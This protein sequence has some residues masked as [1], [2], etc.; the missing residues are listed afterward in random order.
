MLAILCILLWCC[1]RALGRLSGPSSPH[2]TPCGRWGARP[3]AVPQQCPQLGV[4]LLC[5]AV[6]GLASD[7]WLALDAA[8]NAC[9]SDRIPNAVSVGGRMVRRGGTI[10]RPSQAHACI[11][12]RRLCCAQRQ[13]HDL[14]SSCDPQLHQR[15]NPSSCCDKR[16]RQR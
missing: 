14:L 16:T 9:R 2:A 8:A 1:I 5:T 13:H 11:N 3:A 12:A 6:R 4:L 7:A 15:G 10:T